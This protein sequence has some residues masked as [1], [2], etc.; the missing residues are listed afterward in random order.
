MTDKIWLKKPGVTLDFA[1]DSVERT[2]QPSINLIKRFTI[3]P[4]QLLVH[5]A[6]IDE[7]VIPYRIPIRVA[8]AIMKGARVRSFPNSDPRTGAGSTTGPN[9]QQR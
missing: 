9:R 2:R 3:I 7:A 6:I 5:S 8:K 4:W 1:S